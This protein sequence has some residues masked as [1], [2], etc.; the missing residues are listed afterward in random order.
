MEVDSQTALLRPRAKLSRMMP[1]ICRP[2]PTWQ[3]HVAGSQTHHVSG[4]WLLLAD[5]QN[6]CGK[7][8]IEFSTR[9]VQNYEELTPAPSPIKKPAPEAAQ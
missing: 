6:I 9:C 7:I 8:F 2:L 5:C 1:A 4:R 3:Q